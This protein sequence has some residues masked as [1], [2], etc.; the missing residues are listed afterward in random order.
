PTLPRDGASRVGPLVESALA[1]GRPL[2]IVTDGAIDDP[3]RLDRLP[4]G[5][6][7]RLVPA[8]ARPDAALAVLDAPGGALGGDT[9][10]ARIVVR[11]GAAGSVATTLTV[12]LDT[13]AVLTGPLPALEPF[14]EREVRVPI[15]VP[16]TDATRRIRATLTP[17]DA[18]AANDTASAPLV[19]SGAAA[20]TFISSSPDED[21]RFALAVLRG[22]RRGPVQG[23]WRVTP[24]AWRVDGSLRATTEAEVRKAAAA[25]P[26]LVL[27]G[28][29]AIF[30]APRALTR[31]ALVLLAPPPAGDDYYPSGTGDSPI[32]AALAGVPWDSLPPVEV[33]LSRPGGFAAILARRARRFDERAVVV[34]EDGARRAAVVPATG[35]W[36]WRLRGG[37]SAEAFDAVWGSIFDWVGAE[38]SAGAPGAARAGLAR[39]WVP[40]R[41]TVA[42]GTVGDGVPLDRA[43]RALGA[44]WLALVAI[45]ALC[46]EWLLRRRIGLR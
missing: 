25:T 10:T 24:G 20:A 41:P 23:F 34:L 39:E 11:A 6:A 12:M 44:W 28:D 32:A 29:T 7:V 14:E 13:R 37:R 36:R 22:T 15:P 30:G 18:V 3:E 8:V 21:A 40:R 42:A 5:S 38:P 33:G 43:P 1:V 4:Q 17:G 16:A 2:V 26:L 9:I 46:A 35:L 27:H 19:V 31:G 45:V